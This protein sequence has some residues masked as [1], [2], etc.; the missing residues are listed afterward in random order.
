MVSRTIAALLQ[1][2]IGLAVLHHSAI[3]RP[4][5]AFAT[6]LH[7]YAIVVLGAL[8]FVLALALRLYRLG[9]QSLWLDEGGTW[10]EVTRKGWPVLLGELFDRDAAYPLYHLLL[11]AWVALAG[12][13]EWALRFPSAL[14]G[15][16]AVVAIYLAANAPGPRPPATGER[17][18]PGD[19]MQRS[20]PAI[21]GSV[22]ALLFATSPF[23]LWHAQDAKA[24]SLLMLVVALELWALLRALRYGTGR[25]WLVPIALA[26]G[27]LF[28]HR[29][30]LLSSAAAMLAYA[31]IW[32]RRETGD[33]RRE[34]GDGRRET[35]DGR[36]EA[37]DGRRETGD[38]RRETGDGR[39]E[40]GD[41]RRETGDGR[42]ET[43]DWRP[44]T[45]GGRRETRDAR[46]EAGGGRRETGDGRRETI[47]QHAARSTQHIARIG[48]SLLALSVAIVAVA[49][50]ILAVRVESRGGSGHI[51]AG[52]ATGILLTLAHF[53]LDRGDIAGTLGLPLP[54]WA[55]P[56]AVLTMWGGVLVLRDA[57]RRHPPAIAI[58]CMFGVP[59]ALFAAALA[60]RPVY[61]ARYASVAFPAW[62]LV[63]AYPFQEGRIKNSE[64]RTKNS[65][66]RTQEISFLSF[67]L[68][69]LFFVNAI[70][71]IQPAH[72]LFSGAPVKEQWREAIAAL[73]A[74][75]HPDDLVILH[76]YYVEPMWSYYAPRVTPDPLPQPT[77]FP[78]FGAGALNTRDNEAVRRAAEPEFLQAVHGKKRALLLIA[79]D[80][81]V[82]VDPPIAP[83]DRY[84]WVGLRFEYSAHERSWSCGVRKFVGVELLCQSY[85]EVR[86][87]DTPPEPAIRLE[88]TF[89]GELRLRGYDLAGGAARP[90]GTLPVTLYWEAVA[91]PSHD[92][93]MFLHLCRDCTIP[94]LAQDD[95]PPLGGD[96]SDP[97]RTTTWRLHDPVHDE[98][99][100][101]LP[102][103]LASGSY[104]LLLGVYPR[105]DPSAEA[106][107]PVVSAA[108]VLGGT[109]LILGQ[110][111]I[112]APSGQAG[113]TCRS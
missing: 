46:R 51:P 1:R 8:Y 33:G 2:T 17:P 99:A 107:L 16:L 88:A 108:P 95:G 87:L 54:V 23:A 9:A 80:H 69:S 18:E 71:L 89:G 73:A 47:G 113:L 25:A 60:F 4:R 41:E 96:Y 104:T 20:R 97:G 61:E 81:A 35:G 7:R 5:F 50:T 62:V 11:K 103:S 32:P 10:A 72:G 44:E 14:A 98:R 38:R 29:L 13:T 110:V 101:C 91:K 100:I 105:G 74:R 52:P 26:A 75:V 48:F 12:D 70:V 65:E 82:T 30:T 31:L 59:L 37:G 64:Q 78:I 40:A 45:G 66:Q 92:Y 77:T 111:T 76:P 57:A 34:T 22:A 106:R 39:R 55:L 36:R 63:L 24:Y 27:G 6:L 85:P 58:L 19:L 67:V 49:G 112:A 68:C 3:E 102:T 21:A 15:A 43:G 109:R 94:P 56:C 86:G 90:G 42:R 84:G 53:S 93:A 83:G 79:P 28:V